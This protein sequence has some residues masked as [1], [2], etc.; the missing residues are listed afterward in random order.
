M[1]NFAPAFYCPNLFGVFRR[2]GSV[3]DVLHGSLFARL[4]AFAGLPLC[5]GELSLE[6]SLF[7]RAEQL[8]GNSVL[9]RRAARAFV[10]ALFALC[11]CWIFVGLPFVD[12]ACHSNAFL[13]VFDSA[14]AFRGEKRQRQTHGA[15]NSVGGASRFDA[16]A[17]APSRQV[18]ATKTRSREN[19]SEHRKPTCSASRSDFLKLVVP[20][21]IEVAE[22]RA[23][24]TCWSCSKVWGATH[25]DAPATVNSTVRDGTFAAFANTSKSQ[26]DFLSLASRPKQ[27][28]FL[29]ASKE[30]YS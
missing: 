27:A 5:A 29:V 10:F 23:A 8:F 12:R 19:A 22:R 17:R 4:L 16:D 7:F 28:R 20:I 24:A 6:V 1:T 14:S 18:F 11:R 30:S 3:W 25:S 13:L 21:L 26:H 2:V 15:E 9:P